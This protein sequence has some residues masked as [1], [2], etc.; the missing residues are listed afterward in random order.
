MK[1]NIKKVISLVLV[2]A[3]S[4]AMAMPAFAA[5]STVNDSKNAP[6]KNSGTVIIQ[7]VMSREIVDFGPIVTSQSPSTQY[8]YNQ[9]D[10]GIRWSGWLTLDY[11]E[12]RSGSFYAYYSGTVTGHS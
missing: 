12:Y 8:Y 9:I 4:F 3:I 2:L 6:I 10:D 11:S 7:A 1:S 5:E